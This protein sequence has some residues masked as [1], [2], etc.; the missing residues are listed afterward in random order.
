MQIFEI[1][2]WDDFGARSP[3]MV[4]SEIEFF[5]LPLV[6]H[7]HLTLLGMI[8][9]ISANIYAKSQSDIFDLGVILG[10]KCDWRTVQ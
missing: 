4:I 5:K 10:Q 1:L 2:T 9:Y 6:Q 8:E 7:E 3:N